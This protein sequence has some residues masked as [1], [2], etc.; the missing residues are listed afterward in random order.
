MKQTPHFNIYSK[1][2]HPNWKI[3]ENLIAF[4]CTISKKTKALLSCFIIS[5][6]KK[7][8]CNYYDIISPSNTLSKKKS[9]SKGNDLLN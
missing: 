9:L 8:L 3:K 6:F 7:K 5:N 2:D 4:K 1:I